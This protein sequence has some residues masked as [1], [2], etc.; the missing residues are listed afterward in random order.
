MENQEETVQIH[1]RSLDKTVDFPVR[2]SSPCKRCKGTGI[3]DKKP[4]PICCGSGS[5][6][7]F[8]CIR[9]N[10]TKQIE[11]GLKC[12]ICKGEG[13]ISEAK[14]NEFLQA[15]QFCEEF[16][17]KPAKTILICLAC[18]IVLGAC[19]FFISSYLFV[20]LRMIQSL[21][22]YVPLL[23]GL[24][25]GFYVLVTL[26]KMH[27]GSYLPAPKKFMISA[28]VI[29]LGIAAIAIP[30]PVAGRYHWMES[31]AK[32]IISEALAEDNLSCQSVKVSSHDG[33]DYHGFA[34]ISD[35]DK[36]KI[37]IHYKKVEE[38]S[39]EIGYSIEVEPVE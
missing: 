20:D 11:N 25:A 27:V 18:L 16:Q 30:G 15:R 22:I 2:S 12:N 6:K 13:T 32:E 31:E 39:R 21:N 24:G 5:I 26:H 33:N 10:G 35:G 7:M 23:L 1:I 29:A 38:T 9:C 8:D 19:S 28:A 34:T 14:T 37:I 3:K 36:I 17:K 4:C